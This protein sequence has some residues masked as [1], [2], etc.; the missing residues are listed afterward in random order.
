MTG[1]GPTDQPPDPG[2][3]EGAGRTGTT[4]APPSPTV[5]RLNRFTAANML[6]SLL[7]LVVIILVVVGW[8]AFRQSPDVN[9]VKPI[10]PSSTVKLAAARAGYP[11][12][13]PAGLPDGYR[14]TSA[15]TDAGDAGA[16]DPVTLQIGYVTPG[17]QFVG[18]VVSDDPSAG[19]VTTVLGH[20][21][22]NGTV[23]V[24]GRNWTRSTTARGETALSRTDGGVIVLVTGSASERDLE[25][26]AAA[27]RPYPG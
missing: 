21:Q 19:A 4:T 23:A 14:P 25:T 5:E 27:V 20:A 16:G 15:R 22:D 17:E 12:E 8:T 3:E 6:R 10:D 26:V 18:F 13:V 1:S 9:P 11:L 7:P 2:P 24:G